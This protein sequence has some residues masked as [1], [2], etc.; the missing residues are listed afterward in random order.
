MVEV[1]RNS[2]GASCSHL[3]AI[4]VRTYVLGGV[5]DHRGEGRTERLTWSSQ[6]WWGCGWGTQGERLTNR[7]RS[8]PKALGRLR[9]AGALL[10]A[11]SFSGSAG[12]SQAGWGGQ[13]LTVPFAPSG[14]YQRPPDEGG[15]AGVPVAAANGCSGPARGRGVC[16][17][18]RRSRSAARRS[19]YTD[20]T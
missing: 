19:L 9:W 8:R 11:S 17:D 16:G 3:L 15:G 14:P 12:R 4:R 5:D 13:G 2:R 7:I 6:G 1:F 20:C 18:K 10:T